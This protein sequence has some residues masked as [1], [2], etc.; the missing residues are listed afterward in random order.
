MSHSSGGVIHLDDSD[1]KVKEVG[2]DVEEIVTWDHELRRSKT[3]AMGFLILSGRRFESP[4]LAEKQKL[5]LNFIDHPAQEYFL[6]R[7]QQAR[8]FEELKNVC[9]PGWKASSVASRNRKWN[10]RFVAEHLAI[11]LVL[12]RQVKKEKKA[13]VEVDRST[14]SAST[15]VP[16]ATPLKRAFRKLWAR[17][18][19]SLKLYMQAVKDEENV[20]HRTPSLSLQLTG[21][22]EQDHVPWGK[23]RKYESNCPVCIHASTMPLQSR[24]DVNAANARL[25]EAAEANGGNGKFEAAATKVGCY[26]WVQNCFGDRDGIGCW[27][28]VDLAMQGQSS[29]ATRTK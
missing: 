6:S 17:Y 9:K 11:L 29:C 10:V 1:A 23:W 13:Q 12:R 24:E 19:P 14:R 16:K 4:N 22:R 15:G 18:E 25:R 21:A 20:V 28:C 7:S 3:F 26:C 8:E 5:L 27:K 2:S